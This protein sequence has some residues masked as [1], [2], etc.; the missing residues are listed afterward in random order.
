MRFILAAFVAMGILYSGSS[1]D[2][3]RVR[4]RV[5]HE[6]PPRTA[7]GL[8]HVSLLNQKTA[9]FAIFE[10]IRLAFSRSGHLSRAGTSSERGD[11]AIK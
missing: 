10:P 8:V 1:A 11:S 3:Q 6:A 4:G 2:A 7:I 9:S 5:L